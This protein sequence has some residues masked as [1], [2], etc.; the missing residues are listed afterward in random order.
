MKAI[1]GI[2]TGILIVL[3]AAIGIQNTT[4]ISLH[5]F[6]WQTPPL[7]LW[8]LLLTA[9]ASGMLMVGLFAFP[10]QIETYYQNLRQRGQAAPV[11]RP[12]I[13]IDAALPPPSTMPLAV[14]PGPQHYNPQTG[15]RRDPWIDDG[16]K[17]T[18]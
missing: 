17:R 18:V 3:F 6:D 5:L 11:Q 9:L 10:R 15:E 4:A 14:E 2:V 8:M 1:F 13:P 7:P 12:V 16:P